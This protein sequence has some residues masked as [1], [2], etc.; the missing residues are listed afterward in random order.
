MGNARTCGYVSGTESLE[1]ADVG[2]GE[3]GGGGGGGGGGDCESEG[4]DSGGASEGGGAFPSSFEG[5]ADDSGGA[6]LLSPSSLALSLTWGC[7]GGF[8]LLIQRGKARGNE[9]CRK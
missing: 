4:G 7:S 5:G 8:C 6:L 3:G 2:G 9:A 1:M